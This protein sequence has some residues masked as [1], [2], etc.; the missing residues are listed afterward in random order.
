MQ[1]GLYIGLMSGTSLDGID[2]ALVEFSQ[3]G[4]TVRG[5]HYTPW[6]DSIRERLRELC[7]PG[8]NEIDRLGELDVEVA[9]AFSASVKT[10]L[11]RSSIAPSQI[12]AIGSHGQTIRHR[13]QG[14]RPFTLQ[15]GDPNRLAEKTGIKVVA[16]FRRRDMAAGG[17]G[18]PL[19]PAYHAARFRTP[20]EGRAVINIGGIANITLLPKER[21]AAVIGFDTGPGNTL[22]NAWI[23]KHRG[24]DYDDLGRWA[25]QGRVADELLES[26]L[27][28]PYISRSLPKST[29]PEYFNLHWLE[30]HLAKSSH[31]PPQDVQA[32]LTR[33]SSESIAGAVRNLAAGTQ[34]LIVCGGGVHNPVLLEQLRQALP[35]L[36]VESSTAHGLDPDQIEAIAFAW[37]ARQTLSG[38][39]GNLPEVTGARHP[40]ILGG[41]YAAG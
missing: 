9:D 1:N 10:L 23:R 39:S 25:A 7:T 38:L 5:F 16:D 24:V 29:G 36:R 32:T 34:S 15:I 40:V 17:E 2:A 22:I 3:A 13:P 31:L 21:G 33:F 8:V 37:L 12:L 4:E 26:M 41:I 35:G 6:P 11:S 28:D 30:G 19:V 20:D 14:N 18:A 27:S